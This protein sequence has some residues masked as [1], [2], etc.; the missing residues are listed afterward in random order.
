M[1]F[2]VSG[3]IL[4]GPTNRFTREYFSDIMVLDQTLQVVYEV[5]GLVHELSLLFTVF[6][7]VEEC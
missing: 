6:P 4:A 3:S 2:M 1:V 7:E 5:L